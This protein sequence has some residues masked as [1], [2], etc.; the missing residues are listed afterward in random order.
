[1]EKQFETNRR[2]VR[3]GLDRRKIERNEARLDAY[4][5]DM[6]RVSNAKCADGRAQRALDER[7]QEEDRQTTRMHFQR[8]AARRDARAEAEKRERATVQT[9]KLFALACIVLTCLTRITYLP[10]W[11]A[12]AASA[13]LAPLVMAHIYLLHN[14]P[15][16][17]KEADRG[18]K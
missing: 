4:E 5:R 3:D 10:V 16:E 11:G 15:T 17:R 13:G 6:I 7:L 8:V 9:V 12:V 18:R 2:I 1:M 14:P